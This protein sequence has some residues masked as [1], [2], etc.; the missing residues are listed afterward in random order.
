MD[1]L[2]KI[3][4]MFEGN[5]TALANRLRGEIPNSKISQ[6]HINN[7]LLRDKKIPPEW[8]IPLSRV[9]NWEVT[10]HAINARLYPHPHDGLPEHMREVA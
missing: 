1:S 10:P 6:A 8:V 9:S 4:G 3:I 2:L 5:K 7:W